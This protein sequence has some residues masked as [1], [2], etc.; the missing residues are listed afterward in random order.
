MTAFYMTGNA[1]QP[2]T[3]LVWHWAEIQWYLTSVTVVLDDMQKSYNMHVPNTYA[4]KR[5]EGMCK[6]SNYRPTVAGL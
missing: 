1:A 4:H 6:Q 3:Y 5:I 2:L